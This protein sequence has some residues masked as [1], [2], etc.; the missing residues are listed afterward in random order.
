MA[1]LAS[2]RY[3][4]KQREMLLSYLQ[5]VPNVHVTAAEVCDHLKSQGAPI[6]KSTVYRQLESLVNEGILQKYTVDGISPACFAYIGT[7]CQ[8][9]G[10]SCFH[11]KCEKCGR[12]IHL[13]CDELKAVG[14]HLNGEHGF[15]L[16]PVR[17]VFYGLCENCR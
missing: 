5:T 8:K 11:C 4:T 13:R 12:L 16:D 3:Q 9:A 14:V 17:T 15:Q 1:L 2:T 7:D 6:G 10:D